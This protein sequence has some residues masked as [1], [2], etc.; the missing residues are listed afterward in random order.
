MG[1]FY[2]LLSVSKNLLVQDCGSLAFTTRG[3]C[4]QG[5]DPQRAKT[6]AETLACVPLSSLITGVGCG[7][8]FELAFQA[9]C[10]PCISPLPSQS[11]HG[12]ELLLNSLLHLFLD[13]RGDFVFLKLGHAMGDGP[14]LGWD[15]TQQ[16]LIPAQSI[17]PNRNT[18]V[19]WRG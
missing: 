16:Q 8:V 10:F 18:G 17:W 15:L 3:D 13:G 2:Y 4:W 11:I 1:W 12:R 7:A 19:N 9:I 6:G 14:S 5:N